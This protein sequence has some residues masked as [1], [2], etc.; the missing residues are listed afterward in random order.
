MHPMAGSLGA[1]HS[2]PGTSGLHMQH[3]MLAES[4]GIGALHGLNNAGL[5]GGAGHHRGGARR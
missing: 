5:G 2:M 4:G 1:A 3:G